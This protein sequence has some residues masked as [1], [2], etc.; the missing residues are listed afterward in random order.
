MP[1]SRSNHHPVHFGGPGIRT[2]LAI[3]TDISSLRS[4]APGPP[5]S[6]AAS[7]SPRRFLPSTPY[8][9]FGCI[10]SPNRVSAEVIFH[11][12]LHQAR[13]DSTMRLPGSTSG[14]FRHLELSQK[15]AQVLSWCLS[16]HLS[17]CLEPAF[18]RCLCY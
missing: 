5:R 2:T 1:S 16:R 18:S 8:V 13:V 10:G 9:H 11:G 12:Q 6:T 14:F 3:R 17:I 4:P 15:A 7:W